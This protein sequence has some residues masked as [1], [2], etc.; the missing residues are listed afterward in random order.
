[1]SRF[2]S[3]CIW[4]VAVTTL[5]CLS[6]AAMAEVN[7]GWGKW[8]LPPDR[9]THGHAIDSLFLWI[10]W[11]TMIAFIGVEVTLVVFMVKYR[12]KPGRKA[13]FTHGN[14]KLEMAWT[15]APAIILAGLAI[16]SKKVWDNY[17]Y[18][19]MNDDPNRAKVLVIGEQ[20]KWNFIYPGPDGKFGRYLLYPRPSDA[21]WP[22]GEDGSPQR[23]SYNQYRD[24]RGPAD[25]PYDD[26]IKAINAYI[27]DTNP[28][29]K[30]FADPDGKD[31][32]FDKTPGR[33]LVLP[34]H[35]PI[36]VQLSSKDVI[37]DFFLPNFRVKLDAVPGMRGHLA[38]QSTM[39]SAE[40]RKEESKVISID[41]LAQVLSGPGGSD[42]TIVIDESAPGTADNKE[43]AGASWRYFRTT[44]G[45]KATIIRHGQ[46]FPPG[47]LLTERIVALKA[48][49]VTSVR[50]KLVTD[51]GNWEL[52]CAELCGQGHQTMIATVT[53]LS[54]EEYDKLNRDKPFV[55]PATQPAA[56]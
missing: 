21:L 10:F 17:R 22:A 35:R 19:P 11:I 31:D 43:L 15:I 6:G 5:L 52:V 53:F 56:R 3:R 1:M 55:P 9:S 25:M 30:D 47:D 37:H 4:A 13:Y 2:Q 54:N 26:A 28:L 41:S 40:R 12:A 18:S 24:T 36:E 14:Q 34:A 27:A 39:T 49:G 46:S 42:A 38:F 29:G 44:D 20:F 7:P 8:W 16:G 51:T 48:A 32:N 45:T 23:V 50:M 33:A